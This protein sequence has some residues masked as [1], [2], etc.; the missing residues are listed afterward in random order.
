VSNERRDLDENSKNDEELLEPV[1]NIVYKEGSK[2]TLTYRSIC[3][4]LIALVAI[5][6]ISKF[7]FFSDMNIFEFVSNSPSK[8]ALE[9]YFEKYGDRSGSED[10]YAMKRRLG[11]HDEI[12]VYRDSQVVMRAIYANGQIYEID[13]D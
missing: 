1:V 3:I 8:I 12:H 13:L 7:V 10:V 9:Y 2:K 11:C 4:R 6:G 5:I